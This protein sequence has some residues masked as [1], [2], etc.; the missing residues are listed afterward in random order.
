M[1]LY[2]SNGPFTLPGMGIG[3]KRRCAGDQW[4]NGRRCCY[5]SPKGADLLIIAVNIA[6]YYNIIM[7][8]ISHN[9]GQK[10]ET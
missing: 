3:V 5:L 2:Q 8:G 6:K 1:S 4:T 10:M 7:A 9:Y